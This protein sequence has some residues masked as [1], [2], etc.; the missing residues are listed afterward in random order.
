MQISPPQ[1]RCADQVAFGSGHRKKGRAPLGFSSSVPAPP[2]RSPSAPIATRET[3]IRLSHYRGTDV[4]GRAYGVARAALELG[5]GRSVWR[6][7]GP[8]GG[9]GAHAEYLGFL[10]LGWALG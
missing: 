3:G 8:R 4:R 6:L 9:C 10:Q 5:R 2:F 1:P 7:V